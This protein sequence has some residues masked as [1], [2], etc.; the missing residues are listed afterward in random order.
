VDA[1][2]Q[3]RE[4]VKFEAPDDNDVLA[5]INQYLDGLI[6]LWVSIGLWLAS[7]CHSFTPAAF[8]AGASATCVTRA[9]FLGKEDDKQLWL[10]HSIAYGIGALFLFPLEWDRNLLP[11]IVVS[12]GGVFAAPWMSWILDQAIMAWD[13][14]LRQLGQGTNEEVTTTTNAPGAQAPA[15]RPLA[16]E[17]DAATKPRIPKNADPLM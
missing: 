2:T 1:A 8:L 16:E 15:C 13:V 7:L 11:I 9:N 17:A 12:V 6:N 14:F 3:Y 5:S 10:D 4:L